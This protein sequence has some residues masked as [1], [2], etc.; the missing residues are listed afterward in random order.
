ML[1]RPTAEHN[2]VHVQTDVGEPYKHTNIT[3][4][5]FYSHNSF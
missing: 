3:A 2:R 1:C 5:K 4:G